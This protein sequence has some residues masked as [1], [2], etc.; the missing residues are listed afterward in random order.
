M[1]GMDL[2]RSSGFQILL[3][4]YGQWT[5]LDQLH[6]PYFNSS[7]NSKPTGSRNVISKPKFDT[8]LNRAEINV[9]FIAGNL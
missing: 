7:K 5:Y 3:N 1:Y 2:W 8:L 6:V 9:N 4:Q